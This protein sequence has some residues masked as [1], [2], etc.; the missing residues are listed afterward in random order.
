MPSNK[1]GYMKEYY[2]QHKNKWF[3]VVECECGNKLI[4]CNL[5][6]HIKSNKHQTLINASRKNNVT[7]PST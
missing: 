5:S 7:L 4:R 6:H 1:D 2:K 3:E